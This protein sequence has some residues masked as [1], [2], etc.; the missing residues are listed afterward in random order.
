[1][2]NPPD[3]GNYEF[4]EL[5][6]IGDSP[7]NLA[8]LYFDEG[9]RYAFPT[10]STPLAPGELMVLVQNP[11]AFA[12]RYPNVE[13]RGV[14]TGQLSN[15]GEKITLKDIAGNVILSIEYDD[16]NDWPISPDGRGDSLTLIDPHQDPNNPHN[17]RASTNL[18]GSPGTN[19]R[20][21]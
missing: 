21:R 20:G 2:Y 18:Y 5:Q 6:N 1:M 14:Y 16:E 10:D 9:I 17:W 7:F 15:R 13:I 19:D 11:V 4:I 3:G 12:E 8:N